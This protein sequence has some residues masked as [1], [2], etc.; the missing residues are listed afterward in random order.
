[1]NIVKTKVLSPIIDHLT[2]NSLIALLLKYRFMLVKVN[3]IHINDKVI[4][5]IKL[6]IDD[7]GAVIPLEELELKLPN[8]DSIVEILKDSQYA[9]LSV[10]G[11]L[12]ENGST[13]ISAETMTLD[14]L[15]KEKRKTI[16]VAADKA[17]TRW[18]E[19]LDT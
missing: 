14:E 1:M 11:N 12:E 4:N 7:Y 5:V 16:E 9:V 19:S 6:D 8:D 10:Q 17:H 2:Y 18:P 15:N 3:T 13:I